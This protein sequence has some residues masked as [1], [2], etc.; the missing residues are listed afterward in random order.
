MTIAL[1]PEALRWAVTRSGIPRERLERK[2][3]SLPK[4]ESGERRPTYAQAERFAKAVHV[5]FIRLYMPPPE[6]TAPIPDFRVTGGGK[7]DRMSPELIDMIHACQRRQDWYRDYAIANQQPELDFVGSATTATAPRGVA[8]DMRRRLG[9]DLG[10]RVEEGQAVSAMQSLV[11]RIEEI[12]V[13]VMT[14]GVVGNNCRRPL[15][16]GEFRGFALSDR[17]APIVFVNGRDAEDAQMF[18]LMRGLAHVWLGSSG[19]TNMGLE[20]EE[21]RPPEE[22][23]CGDVAAELLVPEDKLRSRFADAVE[24]R[25][26]VSGLADIFGVSERI[27]LFRLL[28]TG[29]I[30]RD[31]FESESALAQSSLPKARRGKRTGGGGFRCILAKRVGRRFGS[32]VVSSTLEGETLHRHALRLLGISSLDALMEFRHHLEI[33]KK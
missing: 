20:A 29:L 23:W 8:D 15:A 10:F 30:N 22:V 18:T 25:A 11:D 16:V 5:P 2:F 14:S 7:P 13:L 6:E 31:R 33:V 9:F 3:A 19:V 21:G 27:I 1:N 12:G 26:S 24:A 4:W 17:H 28:S 32:A